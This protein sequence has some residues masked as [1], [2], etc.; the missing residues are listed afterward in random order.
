[1]KRILLAVVCAVCFLLLHFS[2]SSDDKYDDIPDDPVSPVV[3][4]LTQV[5]YAKLSDY[6][7]FAGDMKN[8]NPSFS[9]LPYE[10]ISSLFTD[11]AKKN[12]YIWMPKN[13]KATY[14][15]D[16]TVFS[17]P[18]G[19][20]LIKNF[21]YDNVLPENATRILETRV[22]IKKEE[23]WIFAQ[24]KW[25]DE[26]TEAYLDMEGSFANITW[27]DEAG[28]TQTVSNYRIPSHAECLICHKTMQTVGGTVVEMPMPI[29]PKPQNLNNIYNYG[30]ESKNQLTKW[31]EFGY[32]DSSNLPSDIQTVV[33]YKD[34]SQSLELR[35]RSY[36][37]INCAHCH[38]ENSHCDYRPIRLAFNE[39]TNPENLG[40]CV[41]SVEFVEPWI[42]SIVAPQNTERSMMY[43]RMSTNDPAY[44]MPLVGRSVTH[45]EGIQLIEE[46]INSLEPCD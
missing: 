21:Y 36:L 41:P 44:M 1:M 33:D 11:Y 19:S 10:P 24:Y 43:Y 35:V 22:M 17:F 5:P 20:A 32:L 38:K 15:S 42:T 27:V 39:T 26:Q 34:A 29:G 40:I 14:N 2:C 7:F 46:W 31:V 4:D 12:R 37:D 18:A 8:Q 6:N 9:V 30:N 28:M 23:G 13:T 25:N 3:L 45:T 16:G